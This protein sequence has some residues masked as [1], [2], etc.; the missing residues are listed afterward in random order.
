MLRRPRRIY[1]DCGGDARSWSGLPWHA[2]SVSVRRREI[3][4]TFG[5]AS[6]SSLL[7]A[8]GCGAPTQTVRRA[9]QVSDEVRVWLRD[10]VARLAT[11]H[12]T[13]H[14]LAVS[15]RRT[16][17]ARDVLGAGMAHL[18]SDGV[19]LTIRDRNGA[20]REQ[21]TSSL[22]AAGVAAAAT[23]LGASRTPRPI[24]F[25]AAPRA[26]TAPIALDERDLRRRV[27]RLLRADAAI[28]RRI[29][30]AAAALDLDDAI[31]WSIAPGRDLEQRLVRIRQ[32]ATRAARNGTRPVVRTLERVWSGAL[33]DHTLTD[34]EITATSEAVLEQTTPGAFEDGAR[35]VVLDPSVVAILVDALVR[36]HLTAP[37]SAEAPGTAPYLTR[38]TGAKAPGTAPNLTRPTG[39]EP[40]GTDPRL[41]RTASA[42]LAHPGAA[43][44]RSAGAALASPLLTLV[45][46]PTT[47]GAYGSFAFDDQGQPAAPLTLLDAGRITAHLSDGAG[48]S[49]RAGHLARAELDSSHLVV[50][51]GNLS[52]SE[53]YSDGFLLEA[54]VDAAIAPFTDQIRISCGRAREL[55]AGSLTGRIYPDVELVG[56]LTALLTA[57]DAIAR[58]AVTSPLRPSHATLVGDAAPPRWASIATPALRTH[59]VVRARRSRA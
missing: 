59:G 38:P 33:D 44:A 3:L 30:Y 42:D 8:L 51:P 39:A 43:L 31:V 13:V 55:R 32:T 28:S 56:S 14:A 29:V 21:A 22:T 6:A 15:R 7:W 23:A 18:R 2:R 34:D 9:P 12:P 47:P 36:R 48:R 35:S 49:R 41:T 1:E 40:P 10:A 20:W 37:T 52:T 16:T 50:T 17:A 11:V 27:E 4:R 58:D 45:D 57:I 19:V 54:G 24:D 46:D 26:A 25:G 5:V 53:L